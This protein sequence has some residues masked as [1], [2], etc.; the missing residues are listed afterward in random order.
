MESAVTKKARVGSSSSLDAVLNALCL[1]AGKYLPRPLELLALSFLPIDIC[2]SLQSLSKS[3]RALAVAFFEQMR[4]FEFRADWRTWM[5]QRM[6]A[7]RVLRHCSQLQS[8]SLPAKLFAWD[9]TGVESIVVAAI[10]ANAATLVEFR[11]DHG[12]ST[13]VVQALAE[14]SNLA[15]FHDKPVSLFPE[16]AFRGEPLAVCRPV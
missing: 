11:A 15:S 8:I 6:S 3:M 9:A 5:D 1:V 12:S 10:R 7:M 14:C 4:R 16:W 13:K 2:A